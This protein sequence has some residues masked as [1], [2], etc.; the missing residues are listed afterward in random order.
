VNQEQETLKELTTD[1]AK[2]ALTIVALSE[3]VIA[4]TSLLALHTQEDK[5]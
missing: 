1:I 2:L 4:A 3:L 5:A